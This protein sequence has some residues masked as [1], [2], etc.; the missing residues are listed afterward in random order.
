[1]NFHMKIFTQNTNESNVT[2]TTN[3]K[4]TRTK[5]FNYQGGKDK[6]L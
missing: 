1:M 2:I 3:W 4:I 5:Q 6:V